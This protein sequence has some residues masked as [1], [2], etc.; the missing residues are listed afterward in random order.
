MSSLAKMT[1][2]IKTLSKIVVSAKRGYAECLVFIV[3]L[4]VIMLIV[5]MLI[6]VMLSVIHY[7]ECRFAECRFALC[8]GA[9]I[10]L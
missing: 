3:M 9:V 5:A 4:C 1:L 8:L 7:A 2:G 10:Q 6:V